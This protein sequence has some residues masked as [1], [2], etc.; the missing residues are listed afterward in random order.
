MR[1]AA[2]LAALVLAGCSFDATGVGSGGD[3]DSTPDATATTSDGPIQPTIDAPLPIDASPLPIDASIPI[4]A[5]PEDGCDQPSDCGSGQTCCQ[6]GG[7]ITACA[8]S[9]IGGSLVCEDDFDCDGNDVC[10]D[11]L[12]GER[13]CTSFCL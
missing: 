12:F 10:C 2:L 3:D 13:E 6:Y 1:S 11:T 4:D 5:P 7:V 9:C 8:D